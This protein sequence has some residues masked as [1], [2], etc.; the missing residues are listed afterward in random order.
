MNWSVWVNLILVVDAFVV[1]LHVVLL[2]GSDDLGLGLRVLKEVLD[3]PKKGDD[4]PVWSLGNFLGA[5]LEQM[6]C[7]SLFRYYQKQIRNKILKVPTGSERHLL[8]LLVPRVG[9][10]DGLLLAHNA[11]STISL[12]AGVL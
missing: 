9:D 10:L 4:L 8:E 1:L 3:G 6:E 5:S 12:L 11:L 2:R 7:F